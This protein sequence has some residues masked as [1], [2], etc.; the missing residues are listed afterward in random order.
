MIYLDHL[1]IKGCVC[2]R[3]HGIKRLLNCS[4]ID[5][6][7]MIRMR[8]FHMASEPSRLCESFIADGAS[9]Q[10]L[11][12]VKIH[13]LLEMGVS[14]KPL[15][16]YV[17][18]EWFFT[19]KGNEWCC[20]RVKLLIS[21]KCLMW[22]HEHWHTLHVVFKISGQVRHQSSG[23]IKKFAGFLYKFWLL[24]SLCFSHQTSNCVKSTIPVCL[25]MWNLRCVAWINA[26]SHTVHL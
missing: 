4:E 21:K 15:V 23:H 22:T 7:Y 10:F 9:M 19:W 13:V 5:E 20:L 1:Y 8:S 2:D 17:T 3:C 11:S 26:L 14:R 16:A 24:G 12:H 18:L 25:L 6:T